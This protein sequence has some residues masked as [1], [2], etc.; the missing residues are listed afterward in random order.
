[1][2][3]CLPKLAIFRAIHSS[4]AHGGD[5]ER[6]RWERERARCPWRTRGIAASE[7]LQAGGPGNRNGHWVLQVGGPGSRDG[8]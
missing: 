1:M 6:A 8:H 3:G 4:L 2:R 5:G 7:V